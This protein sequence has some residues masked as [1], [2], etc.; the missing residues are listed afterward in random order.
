M[1][2]GWANSEARDGTSLPTKGMA[3]LKRERGMCGS[4]LSSRL[5]SGVESSPKDT[6]SIFCSVKGR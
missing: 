6:R 5:Y 2:S 3:S 4:D 1:M